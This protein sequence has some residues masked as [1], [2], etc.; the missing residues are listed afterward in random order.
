MRAAAFAQSNYKVT[1]VNKYKGE[2]FKPE[3]VYLFSI[4]ERAPIDSATNVN[5][6]FTFEGTAR[7]PQLVSVCGRAEGYDVVAAFVLDGVDTEVTLENGAKVKGSET[8]AKMEAITQAINEGG[9]RQ[10]KIQMEANELAEKYNGQLPDSIGQRLDKE[11][12]DVTNQQLKALKEG[13]TANSDNLVPAYFLINYGDVL[14]AG[15]VE[16]F[17][18]TYKYKD[19]VALNI[20]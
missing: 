19:N 14:D 4:E 1:F 17:L 18:S 16:G 3:K 12:E 9:M 7:M 15:F 11:W 2:N 20:A 5:G 6:V 13:I 8:N 10:R